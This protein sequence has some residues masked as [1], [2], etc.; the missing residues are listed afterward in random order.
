MPSFVMMEL[1]IRLRTELPNV[2][3]VG[4]P[5]VEVGPTRTKVLT[6]QES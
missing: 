4:I 1:K 2:A 5:A 3:R 6:M